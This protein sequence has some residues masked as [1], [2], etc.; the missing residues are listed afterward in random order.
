M[1]GEALLLA[2]HRGPVSGRCTIGADR[3]AKGNGIRGWPCGK[4]QGEWAWHVR[5]IGYRDPASVDLSATA[6]KAGDKVW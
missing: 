6:T 3:I 5:A 1:K 2:R 4:P